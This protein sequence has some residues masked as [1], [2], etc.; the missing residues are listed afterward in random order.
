MKS[1]IRTWG[2]P[3]I[4]ILALSVGMAAQDSS[5]LTI[6]ATER[7]GLSIWVRSADHQAPFFRGTEA[8]P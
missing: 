5:T 7:T 4:V 6:L 2:F 8:G 3:A 1:H